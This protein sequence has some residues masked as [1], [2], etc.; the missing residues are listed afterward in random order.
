MINIWIE[1]MADIGLN[2][3]MVLTGDSVLSLS[4]FPGTDGLKKLLFTPLIA[5][6]ACFCNYSSDYLGF[7]FP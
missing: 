5:A 1:N 6:S 4:R 2:E 7:L 3:H